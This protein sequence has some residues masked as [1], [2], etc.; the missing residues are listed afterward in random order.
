MK[1]M[2]VQSKLIRMLRVSLNDIESTV[3]VEGKTVK[4]KD[5]TKATFNVFV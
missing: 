4:F 1:D 3:L 5:G 2:G